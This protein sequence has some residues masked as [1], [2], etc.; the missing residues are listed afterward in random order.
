L[1]YVFE[2]PSNYHE[3]YKK[4]I[5]EC[6]N[7]D[8]TYIQKKCLHL[9]SKRFFTK[10]VSRIYGGTPSKQ[11]K[12]DSENLDRFDFQFLNA[13]RDAERQMFYG[14]NTLLRD[15]LNYFIDYD[16]TNGK[17]FGDI[18]KDNTQELKERE[19]QFN[20]KS[21]ELLGLLIKRIDKDKILE[22]AKET[23]ADKDGPPGFDAEVTE[24]ELLFALRLIVNKCNYNIPIKNN[25]LGYNNLLF[26]AFILAKMQ[27]EA[28]VSMGDNAKVF[29]ILAIEEPEAHLH[30]SM[31]S[32]FLQFLNNNLEKEEQVRQVFITTHSTHITSAVDLDSVICLYQDTQRRSSIGYPARTFQDTRDDKASKIYIQRFLD[33]TKSNMLFADRIIFVEGLSEQLLLPCFAQYLELEK[34]LIDKH[35]CIISIDSR[36]FKHFLKLYAYSAENQYAIQKRVV[37]ITD[38]DPVMK[39]GN[40]WNSVFP[41][42]L[43]ENADC[44][45]LSSHVTEL[46]ESFEKNCDNIHIFHPES[47]LGKT[48]EYEIC[49][50]NPTSTLLITQCFPKENSNYTSDNYK[51]LIGRFNESYDRFIQEY[52]NIFNIKNGD[53][54]EILKNIINCTWDETE[55]KSGDRYDLL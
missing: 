40:R 32:K 5:E 38:A 42:E 37:C 12:A 35:V 13:I 30:P 15:V 8:G 50:T 54:D 49:R 3:D 6:K 46:K 33:A 26:I 4:Q 29:P 55:K 52:R 9:I 21:E 2:L 23:G 10:Y 34:D 25:G 17:D 31:Q 45:P 43:I 51:K 18:E 53:E 19:N 7:E 28:S 44:R 20:E 39:K 24:R 47:G 11:E 41:F 16:L 27:M 1:T 36:T 48:F 22:Y 14:N